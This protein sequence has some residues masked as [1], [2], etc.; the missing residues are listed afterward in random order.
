MPRSGSFGNKILL[1]HVVPSGESVNGDLYRWV[2]I[3]RLQPAAVQKQSEFIE[4]GPVFLHDDAGP[5]R[6][7]II[8]AQLVE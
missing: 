3:H 8:V 2:L 5:H 4:Q 7:G 1:D 6:A